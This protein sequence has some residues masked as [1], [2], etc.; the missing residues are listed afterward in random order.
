MNPTDLALRIV[1]LGF[2]AIMLLVSIRA[3]RRAKSGRMIWI[4]ISFAGF[5][6]LSSLVLIGEVL[7]DADWSL[8]NGA[9]LILLLII[10]AN[11]LALLKG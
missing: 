3:V 8:S 11:Y 5:T 1:L 4:V 10:G 2:S 7:D 6:A 9:V